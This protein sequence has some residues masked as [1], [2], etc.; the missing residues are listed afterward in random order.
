M[1]IWINNKRIAGHMNTMG[2][3]RRWQQ[4][5][6][7]V[8]SEQYIRNECE[9]NRRVT[10]N[11]LNWKKTVTILKCAHLAIHLNHKYF[12][13]SKLG[14]KLLMMSANF[15]TELN[16]RTNEPK[17]PSYPQLWPIKCVWPLFYYTKCVAWL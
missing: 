7:T 17:M 12:S 1:A 6:D 13:S 8:L 3:D 4:L 2:Y 11:T 10:K 5:F 15:Q 14:W 9:L 16:E